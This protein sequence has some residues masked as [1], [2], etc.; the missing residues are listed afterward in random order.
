MIDRLRQRNFRKVGRE[1]NNPKYK[2]PKNPKVMKQ[3]TKEM[4][5][6]AL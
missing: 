6:K 3:E 4:L 2:K 5:L 1:H